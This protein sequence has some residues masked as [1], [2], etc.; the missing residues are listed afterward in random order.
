MPF[1]RFYCD[2]ENEFSMLKEFNSGRR[3]KWTI[4]LIL[5]AATS[6][7]VYIGYKY[8]PSVRYNLYLSADLPFSESDKDDSYEIL[9]Y[10]DEH[11]DSA[12]FD[13]FL[14]NELAKDNS[15]HGKTAVITSYL[16]ASER[17]YFL[18]TLEVKQKELSAIQNSIK[19]LYAKG[20]IDD[21]VERPTS[22]YYVDHAIKLWGDE[23]RIVQK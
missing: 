10:L 12:V 2:F 11:S 22:L 17:R 18:P 23:Y 8:S 4:P 16:I 3:K 21:F 9:A 7:C 1:I 5:I 14:K 19:E 20:V 6:V 15:L 13:N